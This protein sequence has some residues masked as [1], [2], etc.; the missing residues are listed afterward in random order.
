[1][2]G[3]RDRGAPISTVW[4]G[5]QQWELARSYITNRSA[6]SHENP[7]RGLADLDTGEVQATQAGVR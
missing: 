1:M 2:L 7:D 6:S 3:G 5:Q 4:G